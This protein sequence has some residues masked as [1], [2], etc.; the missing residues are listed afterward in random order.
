MFI[1]LCVRVF[2]LYLLCFIVLFNFL[3]FLIRDE[4]V[5]LLAC[6]QYQG[7]NADYQSSQIMYNYVK[8]TT[9]ERLRFLLWFFVWSIQA[10]ASLPIAY[11]YFHILGKHSYWIQQSPMLFLIFFIPNNNCQ[12]CFCVWYFSYPSL[13]NLRLA[14]D[15]VKAVIP[16]IELQAYQMLPKSTPWHITWHI[17]YVPCMECLPT[18]GWF[19]G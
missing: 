7:K 4:F 5:E 14:T 12:C 10:Y 18:F 8:L 19:F 2:F 11:W 9:T 17:P 6:H 13:R 3:S 15:F 16:I 1:A